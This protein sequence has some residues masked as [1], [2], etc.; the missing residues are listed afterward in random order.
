MRFTGRWT[1]MISTCVTYGVDDR[2]LDAFERYAKLW[3]P[4]VQKFGGT[5]HGYFLPTDSAGRDAGGTAMALYTFATP[6][7]Y[8]QWRIGQLDDPDCRLAAAFGRQS[9]CI[10]SH[11]RCFYRPVFKT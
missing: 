5:H 4:M 8:A 2:K 10:Q 6:V 1:G 9:G 3:I 7:H 11:E